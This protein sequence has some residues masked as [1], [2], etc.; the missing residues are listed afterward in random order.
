MNQKFTLISN[1]SVKRLVF[2]PSELLDTFLSGIPICYP[3]GTSISYKEIEQQIL[4]AQK[5]VENYL[6]IKLFY[7]KIFEV[8]DFVR[9]HFLQ[10]GY[11]KTDFPIMKPLS[12]NGFINTTRQVKYPKEWLSVIKGSD[13][14]KYRQLHLI[15]NTGDAAQTNQY[16]VVFSGITP[17]LGFFGSDFIPNYWH[18]EY[19]TGWKSGEIPKDIL[20]VIGKL[21]SIQLLAIAGDLIFGAGISNQSISIDGISQTYS[22][23]KSSKGAFGGRIEQYAKEI[24]IEMQRLK[25]EYVGILF[26]VF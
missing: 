13:K 8:K 12:L 16:N 23:T 21:A 6:S 25:G 3:D 15:P 9:N 18:I 14:T 5:Q 22:T 26:D 24:E 20:N 19:C 7:Q 10:W 4:I 17:H 2:S 11:V 1:N